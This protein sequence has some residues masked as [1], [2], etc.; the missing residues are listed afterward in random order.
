MSEAARA[1]LLG[2]F[3]LAACIWVGGYVAIAVVAQTARATL[4]PAERVQFF[5]AL[6]R[7]YLVV[8][9]PALAV[10]LGGGA[11]LL[12]EHGWDATVA[13][14]VA[15]AIALVAAL[16]IGVVQARRMTR[17]RAAALAK[18]D[19]PDLER[20]VQRGARGAL[21]LRASIGLLSLALIALGSV[22]A[23]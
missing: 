15:V 17:L 14:A 18:P 22:L 8:G 11:G 1:A 10:A 4:G 6:G 7:R 13:A 16:A 19:D 20:G 9:A 23:G 2:V 5:R 21:V 3:L 12:S